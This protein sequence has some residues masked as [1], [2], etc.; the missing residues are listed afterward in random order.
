VSIVQLRFQLASRCCWRKQCA[1]EKQIGEGRTG[2]GY[3]FERLILGLESQGNRNAEKGV[4][5]PVKND[6][7]TDFRQR[8]RGEHDGEMTKR[9][10]HIVLEVHMKRPRKRPH[11]PE[12]NKGHESCQKTQ[13]TE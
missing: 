4:R 6:I 3:I 1:W 7:V 11:F 5:A 9:V 13:T 2:L 10:T 12:K 8:K